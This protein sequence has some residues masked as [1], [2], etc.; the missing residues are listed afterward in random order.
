MVKE[1]YLKGKGATPLGRPL[2][3]S[4]NIP[5]W[6]V[7]NIKVK[8]GVTTEKSLNAMVQESEP[9]DILYLKLIT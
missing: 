2:P 6:R 8:N 5:L 1:K 4:H 7:F 3:Q 9:P